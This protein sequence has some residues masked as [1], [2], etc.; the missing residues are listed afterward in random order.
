MLGG[1]LGQHVRWAGTGPRN[2]FEKNGLRERVEGLAGSRMR[3]GLAQGGG[4][5]TA[6]LGTTRGPCVGAGGKKFEGPYLGS[7]AS[8]RGAIWSDREGSRGPIE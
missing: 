4:R 5:D 8:S 6:W 3:G 2:P 7:G 1:V